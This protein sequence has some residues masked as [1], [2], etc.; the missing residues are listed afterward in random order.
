MLALSWASAQCSSQ[1]S[2]LKENDSLSL[3]S[4]IE[5]MC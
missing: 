1:F 3:L 5:M 2:Y 4:A